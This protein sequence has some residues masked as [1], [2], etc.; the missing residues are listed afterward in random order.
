M[1]FH[2]Y[3]FY[4]FLIKPSGVVQTHAANPYLWI[5]ARV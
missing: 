3:Y 4:T 2:F 5:T 1:S